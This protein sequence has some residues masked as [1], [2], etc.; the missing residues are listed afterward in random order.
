MEYVAS[1]LQ[2]APLIA[3][4]EKERVGAKSLYGIVST[5]EADGNRHLGVIK[6][7]QRDLCQYYELDDSSDEDESESDDELG[8]FHRSLRSRLASL[9]SFR[10]RPRAVPGRF[11]P[12]E[13]VIKDFPSVA[14]E[15]FVGWMGTNRLR[16]LIPNFTYVHRLHLE[17]GFLIYEQ[18]GRDLRPDSD[19]HALYDTIEKGTTQQLYD[20]LMQV[21]YSIALAWREIGFSH[22]DLHPGNV[23]E[24]S[25][26]RYFEGERLAS[27]RPA[28]PGRSDL[29]PPRLAPSGRLAYID[30]RLP[31]RELGKATE[32]DSRGELTPRKNSRES[33]EDELMCVSSLAMIIDYECACFV[34]ENIPYGVERPRTGLRGDRGNILRD[35]Y[36]L[37]MM[38]YIWCRDGERQGIRIE[39]A[40]AKVTM[41]ERL[42]A[43]ILFPRIRFDHLIRDLP[44][45]ARVAYGRRFI[46]FTPTELDYDPYP[47][48]LR[49]RRENR[50][51]DQGLWRRREEVDP[52]LIIAYPH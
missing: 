35:Y 42:I 14:H 29:A 23:L 11:L 43:Q 2:S 48:L 7:Y 15:F 24:Q 12:D 45:F 3:I 10:L 19:H 21:L 38:T 52:R 5:F 36:K 34:H 39:E 47:S 28:S 20:S 8:S 6:R 49:A 1:Y 9:R 46:L 37:L 16:A 22:G 51:Y 4:H 25:L 32:G 17:K 40:S 18:I 26:P 33:G 41:A 50:Q 30:Y 31:P 27:P 44:Q 13:E